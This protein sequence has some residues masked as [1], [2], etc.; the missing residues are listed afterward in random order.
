[1]LDVRRPK[2]YN[3]ETIDIIR[4]N[5]IKAIVNAAFKLFAKFEWSTW[6]I[7]NTYDVIAFS[8][9]VVTGLHTY[10]KVMAFFEGFLDSICTVDI[11]TKSAAIRVSISQTKNPKISFNSMS[12]LKPKPKQIRRYKELDSS[13]KMVE[14]FNTHLCYRVSVPISEKKFFIEN[15][16][17][18]E[19]IQYTKSGDMK[20]C[21]D[22][23]FTNITDRKSSYKFARACVKT[24]D[25][26]RKS[27]QQFKTP[28]LVNN[29]NK[30]TNN[31]RTVSNND[32]NYDNSRTFDNSKGSGDTITDSSDMLFAVG[33]PLAA[34]VV[35]A[36]ICICKKKK[37]TLKIEEMD[38]YEYAEDDQENF[39]VAVK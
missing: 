11:V 18:E 22:D 31:I 16:L 28:D 1:M 21:I 13:L 24:T 7:D 8:F 33:L 15:R 34:V 27:I 26:Y 35:V 17:Q 9:T 23:V 3:Q 20:V 30:R 19:S 10:D 6:E 4:K 36:A 25:D 38:S 32:P 29:K 39:Q 37:H 5:Y 12:T 14:V 2:I